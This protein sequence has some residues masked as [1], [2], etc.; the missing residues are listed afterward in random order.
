MKQLS[1]LIIMAAVAGGCVSPVIPLPPPIYELKIDYTTQSVTAKNKKPE[2]DS[3]YANKLVYFYNI[4]SGEGVITTADGSGKY[5]TAPVKFN[6]LD[7]FE[8]WGARFADDS[9]SNIICVT[10]DKQKGGGYVEACKSSP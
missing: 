6:D 4:M 9:P 3:A 8:I 7:R 10:M 1:I 5:L 2:G